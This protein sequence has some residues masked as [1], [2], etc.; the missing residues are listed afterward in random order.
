MFGISTDD[1]ATQK[2]FKEELKLPYSL[3]SDADGTVAKQ[4]SGTMAVV[5]LAS[6][7]NVVIGQDGKVVQVVAGKDAID[8]GGAVASC[9]VRKKAG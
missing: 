3:L 9:P 2:R 1:V 4:Y 7:A 5:G 8:A 6:R